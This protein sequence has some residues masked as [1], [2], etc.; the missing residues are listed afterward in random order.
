MSDVM[1][2]VVVLYEDVLVQVCNLARC[3]LVGGADVN[4]AID[5]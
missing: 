1:L 4:F 3:V 2:R 5:L